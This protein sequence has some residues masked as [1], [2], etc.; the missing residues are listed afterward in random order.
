MVGNHLWHTYM[1]HVRE[2]TEELVSLG[3]CRNFQR[4]EDALLLCPALHPSIKLNKCSSGLKSIVSCAFDCSPKLV[5]TPVECGG[6][7]QLQST[8]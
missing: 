4:I 2:G 3:S 6:T 7:F 1:L 5:S 8:L